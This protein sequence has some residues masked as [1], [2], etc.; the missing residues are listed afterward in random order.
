MRENCLTNAS[1]RVLFFHFFLPD[2]LKE[3]Y[4]FPELSWEEDIPP[5]SGLDPR[6]KG[7]AGYN[8]FVKG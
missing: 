3:N 6:R 5:A 2:F 7:D 8:L 4:S 1:R